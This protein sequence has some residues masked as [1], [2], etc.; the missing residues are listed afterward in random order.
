MAVEAINRFETFLVNNLALAKRFVEEI[1]HPQV[2]LM[3]DLFHMGIE[4]RCLEQS[5]R[6]VAPEL[7][8]VHL[9]DNTREPAG[10]G[11]TDF[12][13]VLLTLREIGYAGALTMEFLP[14]VANP[15]VA[16][17]LGDQMERMDRYA[18]QAISY[19]RELERTVT[20]AEAG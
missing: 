8:H 20:C 16:A 10:L 6:M 11:R 2:K 9:A 1:D 18:M 3:A 12:K 4:E 5:L 19:I 14:R 17:G 7:V 13:S 15:Y